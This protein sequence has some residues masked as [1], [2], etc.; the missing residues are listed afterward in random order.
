MAHELLLEIGTEELPAGYI[1]PALES[2][3]DAAEASLKETRI[4]FK[5]SETHGTPRRLVL[6]LTG[7]AEK[8][9]DLVQEQQ[10]PAKAVA[11]DEGGKPTKAAIG[12]ARGRG[13]SV[14][15]LAVKETPRGEYVFATVV[16]PGRRTAEILPSLLTDLIRGL[17]FPKS[18]RWCPGALRFARPIRWLL[19]L[20]GSQVIS[21]ALDGLRSGNQTFGHRQLSP[22]PFSVA[23]A[24][25]YWKVLAKTGIIVDPRLRKQAIWD[26]LEKAADSKGGRPLPNEHLLETVTYLVELP[27]ALCGGFDKVYL[28]LPQ[29]VLITAMSEHQKYFA[30]AD[31]KGRLLPLFLAVSN[32]DPQ[33]GEFIL[34]G[35]QKVLAARLEDA[36]FFFQEDQKSPLAKKVDMLKQVVFQEDLGT[37]Y[38]KTERI[39]ALVEHLSEVLS[40]SQAKGRAAGRA[41]LL[42]KADLV[43]H[44]V[45][46][47]EFSKLQGY[48]GQ[49]YALTSG[50]PE[51][52]ALAILEHYLPR[53]AEDQLPQS[54]PGS[55]V[56]IADKVDTIAGCFGVGL[57]PTGSH[58]PYALRRGA[59]GVIRILLGHRLYLN[60]HQLVDRAL[61]LLEKKLT[62]KRAAAREGILAFFRQ[63]MEGQLAEAGLEPDVVDAVLSAADR[64]VVDALGR[65]Q[66]LQNFRTR[67]EFQVLIQASKRV[68][69]ILRGQVVSGAPDPSLFRDEAESRLFQAAQ[70]AQRRVTKSLQS[71]AYDRALETTL[72]LLEPIDFFFE[73]ILVMDKDRGLRE[74]RLRLLEM[75]REGFMAVADTSKIVISGEANSSNQR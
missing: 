47:K 14:E 53:F 65:G 52:V 57:I 72:A 5:K 64:D 39:G 33:S 66:A 56:A 36:K 13:V 60:L 28:S 16:T 35:H 6:R 42:C 12:F 1:A 8:Q 73:R 45:G 27:T 26:G 2:L 29:E 10:G 32:G 23:S 31:E 34:T 24:S 63:R 7:V 48:M 51:A 59:L 22:G 55:V 11:F 19:A 70:M 43:T 74:N 69:H 3:K 54:I 67:E 68:A 4:L 46:E 21:F 44:M 38:E 25:D 50:E 37:L 41:A 62:E 20:L 58:D 15:D 17:P 71:R 49:Q 18:M 61:D 9:E 75:V 30:A 40:L